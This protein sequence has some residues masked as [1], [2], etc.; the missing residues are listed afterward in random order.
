MQ[1]YERSISVNAPVERLFA[2]HT[3]PANLLRI[4]PKN[5]RVDILRHDPAGE[6]AIVEVRV[7]FLPFLS[8][9]WRLRFEV[10]DPP[11]RLCDLQ[12]K[13]PFRYWRQTREFI[14]LSEDSSMLHDVLEYELP[15]GFIGAFLARTF[16]H[17]RVAEM[18][19]FRQKETKRLIEE[20]PRG[21]DRTS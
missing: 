9:R 19:E 1:R 15:G 4:T 14:P 2:F 10:F 7:R 12:E 21:D 16:V 8:T 3:D 13:G 17:T 5:V 6:G 18:F 20:T 11:R